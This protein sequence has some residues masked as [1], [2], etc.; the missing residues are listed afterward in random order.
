[1]GFEWDFIFLVSFLFKLQYTYASPYKSD[2]NKIHISIYK[3][4]LCVCVCVRVSPLNSSLIGLEF[5]RHMALE[6]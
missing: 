5:R 1:M 3:A 2:W 4:R 6:F